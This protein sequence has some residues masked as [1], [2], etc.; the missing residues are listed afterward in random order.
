MPLSPKSR[1]VNLRPDVDSDVLVPSTPPSIMMIP[2]GWIPLAMLHSKGVDRMLLKKDSSIGVLVGS[3]SVRSQQLDSEPSYAVQADDVILVMTSKGVLSFTLDP[4]TFEFVRRPDYYS[5]QPILRSVDAGFVYATPQPVEAKSGNDRQGTLTD[6][7]TRR[8]ADSAVKAYCR[9]VEEAAAEGVCIHPVVARVRILDAA[10]RR[11]YISEPTLLTHPD[12]SE[13]D[14][15]F[16]F[17]TGAGESGFLSSA[18]TSAP[19]WRPSLTMPEKLLKSL[20]EGA[21]VEV[22][23][24]DQLDRFGLS[25]SPAV[26][27]RRHSAASLVTVVLSRSRRDV[28]SIAFRAEESLAPAWSTRQPAS[29]QQFSFSRSTSP[30]SL[31]AP[32]VRIRSAVSSA[33]ASSAIVWASPTAQ[34]PAPASP[35][36]YA[37]STGTDPWHGAVT[38]EFADGSSRVVTAEGATG[39]PTL[40]SPLLSYPSA[41]AVALSIMISSR[42]EVRSGRFPLVADLSGRRSVYLHTSLAP[43]VLPDILPVFVPPVEV[44]AECEMPGYVAVAST[45]DPLEAYAATA[46]GMGVI[47][48]V[49]PAFSGQSAWDFGRSRFYVFTTAGTYLMNADPARRAAS[50]TL[51]DS[52]TVTAF[53]QVDG[54]VAAIASGDIV[55]MSGRTIRRI[56]RIPD[57][58]ALAWNHSEHELWAITPTGVE[59]VCFDKG[60]IRYSIPEVYGSSPLQVSADVTF[61]TNQA[62]NTF[63]VGHGMKAVSVDIRFA[64]TFAVRK[65]RSGFYRAL[66]TVDMPGYFS[67]LA[68]SGYRTNEA[69]DVPDP[70]FTINLSGKI[71][72]PL[73]IPVLLPSPAESVKIVISGSAG[74]SARLKSV[75]LS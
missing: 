49:A 47:T 40:I 1:R 35:E 37:A 3:N 68:I 23:A 53:C 29:S 27:T 63:Q 7:E 12:G 45:S 21:V 67:T 54:A 36:C 64:K 8:F 69:G 57:A 26:T 13:F 44:P 2:N 73:R 71:V 72:A 34:R 25:E 17:D 55:L 48:G 39:A 41:D 51:V 4:E 6:A 43:F 61:I 30:F 5:M 70:D 46:P 31:S 9:L 10:G 38:V 59:V 19:A 15:R 33:V 28:K 58:V 66:L 62:G 22:L 65:T 16:S 14:G 60:H 50:L 56:D 75:S 74:S 20:P 24:S 32:A 18:E 42:G 11:I 52:R